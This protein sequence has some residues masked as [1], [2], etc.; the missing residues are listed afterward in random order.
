MIFK[1]QKYTK[2]HGHTFTRTEDGIPIREFA[3]EIV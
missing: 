3:Y 2:E 1:N